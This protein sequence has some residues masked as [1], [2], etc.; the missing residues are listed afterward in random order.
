MSDT[1]E[2]NDKRP[3]DEESVP[4]ASLGA[5]VMGI[6]E[7]I[8]RYKLLRIL[9]EG[10]FGIVYLA[11]QQRPMKRQVAL[12]I[13]KPGMDSAQVI[14]RFEAERQA[15]ALLDH[16]NVAHVHDAGTTK[17]GRPYFVMEY[18]KGAP[19]TEHCDRQKFTIE[20][21]L[22]LFVKVCE[23]IQH[24]HQ[25]GIIHRDIKPS[26]IQ[27]CIQGEQF[28]P[29]VIDFGVAK[30]LT[31]PLTER[32]LVTEQGQMLGTP[33]YIS[34]EQAE[35]TNQDIDTRSDIYSLGV[36]LYELLTG[37]LPFDPKALRE[38][39]VDHIRHVIR[40][41]DPKTPSTRL[42]TISG[43]EST[44][45]AQLRRTD[46]RT[47]GR[48]L[49]G[50]LDWITLMAMEKDRTRRYETVNALAEDIQRHL[51]HEPVQAGPPGTTYRLKKFIRRH[52]VSVTTAAAVSA[53]VVIGLAVSTAM[54]LQAQRALDALDRL[55]NKV[56]ADVI[57]SSA[58][59]LHAEGRY[60]EAIEELETQL[61]QENLGAKALL[62]Q[63]QLLFDVG[64]HPEAK[65]ILNGLRAEPPEIAGPAHYLLARI[66]LHEDPD[67][68][69]QHRQIAGS[70]LPQTAEAYSLRAMTADTPSDVITW[71]SKA[72]VLD[73][74]HYP[75]RKA[76]ALA[77]YGLQQYP[78]M[79]E[80]VGALIIIRPRDYFGY[81]LRA[82]T[83]RE[84]DRFD[85]ALSDHDRAI[86][87]CQK[88]AERLELY[89][90]RRQTHM[91]S[92]N[93]RAALED[94][95][96]CIALQPDEP[97]LS[98]H[99]FAALLAMGEYDRAQALYRKVTKG[100][101]LVHVRFRQTLEKYAYDLLNSG[102]ELNLP[103]DI[104][105]RCPFY[106][107]EKAAQFHAILKER[108]RR[109]HL[110]GTGRIGD[111]SPDG[112]KIAYAKRPDSFFQSS[113]LST[114]SAPIQA[115]TA[116][117]GIE[118]MDLQSRETQLLT[119]FG[120]HPVWSPDSK[121]I[122]FDGPFGVSNLRK[123]IWLVPTQGGS[124]RKLA[125]G[126]RPRW[127]DDSRHV[128]FKNRPD[129]EICKL[130]ILDVDASPQKVMDYPGPDFH[131]AYDYYDYRISPD[132]RYLALDLGHAIEILSWPE[133]S[134][135][136][137]WETPW[138]LPYWGLEWHPDGEKL[139]ISARG[140][141][142]PGGMIL[143]DIA[144]RQAMHLFHLD[145]PT[146]ETRWSP[147]GRK[148]FIETLGDLWLLE[149]ES[150]E[151]LLEK[152]SPGRPGD[153]HFAYLRSQWDQVIATDPCSAENYVS[154]AL[155]HIALRD[156]DRAEAD[157]KQCV[158]LIHDSHDPTISQLKWW[159]HRFFGFELD[160][161]LGI[162][163]LHMVQ[164]AERF[165]TRFS[166]HWYYQ[167]PFQ[168]LMILSAKQGHREEA[169]KWQRKWQQT[170]PLAPGSLS[171]DK[172][173]NVY[174]LVG[175]GTDIWHEWDEFHFAFKRLEGSGSITARIDS[176]QSVDPWTKA[177]VVIRDTLEPGSRN[178]AVLITP[179][180]RVTFQHRKSELQETFS[181]RL[182]PNSIELPHWVK[183]ERRGN[184]F[185]AQHSKDGIQWQDIVD[186][187]IA[188]LSSAVDIEMSDSVYVGLAVT[189]HAGPSVT[190]EAKISNVSVTGSVSPDGPFT[191]SQ[192]IGFL[193]PD[194]LETES[195]ND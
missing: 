169:A 39:G 11:E 106:Y 156:Y 194:T 157:L 109:H 125:A 150:K 167:H 162:F 142:S 130:D 108:G 17:L 44:K 89:N 41:E 137:R 187:D 12:K 112:W 190:A 75:S 182:D 118:V 131:R 70:I 100:S 124:V 134:H 189:S 117:A 138:P 22:K 27:V 60:Q 91:Q 50:D 82:I 48:K 175:S 9:G 69:E 113:T 115:I 86:A 54:Y 80:D 15:L 90:Q 68:A 177:G 121:Y 32:T 43:E 186:A 36:V 149:A 152:L 168:Y 126:A 183:L 132:G 145:R 76:R 139:L 66:A 97:I 67:L 1:G 93:Y 178:A 53:A 21:R 179:S 128:Y 18:V 165:P 3:I 5:G 188:E 46:V 16:P 104:A 40:E 103:K 62:L 122:A 123:S 6:G 55:E 64:Q 73:P 72:L 107:I 159:A 147:D 136:W 8:G 10:G 29:K 58:Q 78:M 71:L 31:Q 120:I 2:R 84:S 181:R 35:M 52:R 180:R 151:A 170:H 47:L 14:R 92:G 154:R 110:T 19:I 111:W 51:N 102:E 42:S 119:T 7:R 173:T 143:L 192:D 74:A 191:V 158:G 24:A 161:E 87:L 166:P 176:I 28:V 65:L 155:V 171:Y 99:A 20:E 164:L 129:M 96:R 26:N 105:L 114:L 33:E 148:L 34:P 195:N 77:Y 184:T 83:H 81:A 59:R 135:V 174:T 56:E 85:Q 144:Q 4:T 79:A 63:A 61:N 13:I 160:R 25:K 127:S 38:G 30:A 172:H 98:F 153:Q 140:F 37:A 133:G 101:Q 163:A 116:S 49:H 146:C 57:L 23:A 141:Y 193:T 94:A 185:S 88:P 45:V 95:N